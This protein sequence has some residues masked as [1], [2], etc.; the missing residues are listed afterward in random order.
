VGHFNV[1]FLVGDPAAPEGPRGFFKFY[2]DLWDEAELGPRPVANPIELLERDAQGVP[3][4]N[5]NYKIGG[6]AEYWGCL[7]NPHWLAVLKTWT[8]RGIERGVDGYM[9]N[10]FYRHNCLCDHCQREFKTYL[11]ERFTPDDLRRSFNIADLKRHVFPEIVAWHNPQESTPLRR[12]MLRFSQIANKRAFDEVFIR[13]GRSLRPGLIVGQWN[14]LGNFNQIS[15]DERSLL[16]AELWGKDEDYLWYSTGGS[17]CFTDL[18][19]GFLGEG[20]LHAR[21]IR[22]SFADKPFTLGKYENTRIRVAIAE[23]AANGGAPMGFYTR[24]TDPAAR[25]EIVRYYN[26]LHRYNDLHKA[27]RPHSEVALLYP[28]RAVLEGNLQPLEAFR[29]LGKRLLDQHVLFD[30]RPD[31]AATDEQLVAYRHVFRLQPPVIDVSGELPSDVR[32]AISRF[33]APA[34]VRVSANRPAGSDDVTLHFVNYNRTEPEKKHSP[35]SG[36]LDEKPIACQPFAVNFALPA[37]YRVT[38]VEAMTPEQQA[39]RELKFEAAGNRIRFSTPGFLV[40][41][42]VRLALARQE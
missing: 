7:N 2:R 28:R 41:A 30:V 20:T 40:Y 1:K 10:Y 42:V 3:L 16:P 13:Y 4:V 21:Y 39:A 35:G 25:A 15:G 37:G 6:M 9:I 19:E 32:A 34:T 29:D 17:A 26:F 8:R 33:E 11:A 12:E 5:H 22:G 18:A 24:F 31:D 23:L 27:N 14:H 36:I 38:R